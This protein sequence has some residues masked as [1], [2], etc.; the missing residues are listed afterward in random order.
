MNKIVSSIMSSIMNNVVN[1]VVNSIISSI[2]VI[3]IH[4]LLWYW[5]RL[6]SWRTLCYLY[7]VNKTL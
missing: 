6:D 4:T 3:V 7:R 5:F 2:I 1:N